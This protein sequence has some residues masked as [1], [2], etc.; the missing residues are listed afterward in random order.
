MKGGFVF[1][2]SAVGLGLREQTDMLAL[3]VDARR[4]PTET[5]LAIFEIMAYV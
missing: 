1:G 5:L 4:L 3:L 2:L